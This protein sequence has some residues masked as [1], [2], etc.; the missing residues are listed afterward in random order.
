V[1]TSRQD[2]LAAQ[3]EADWQAQVLEWARLGGWFA[4]SIH[5]SRTQ[6]WA[7]SSGFPD[8]L[9]VRAERVIAAE[10][11][12]ETGRLTNAQAEWL[13]AFDATG[14]V[15]T[16]V[17]RPSMADAVRALL[18]GGVPAH[19]LFMRDR[20]RKSFKTRRRPVALAVAPRA[21]ACRLE[22]EVPPCT[23]ILPNITMDRSAN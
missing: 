6:H 23:T 18:L 10:L 16:Y 9:L 2:I 21:S 3:S 19:E 17:W 15:E 11:K 1:T 4:Y 8:L 7:T 22:D 13:A 20:M 5:D 12:T 14:R